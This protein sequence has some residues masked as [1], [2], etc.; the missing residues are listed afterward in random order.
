MSTDEK[1]PSDATVEK[2]YAQLLAT[3]G[4]SGKTSIRDRTSSEYVIRFLRAY[5]GPNFTKPHLANIYTL[6]F[7]KIKRT[8]A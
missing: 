6:M 2:S 3:L 4:K 1:S 8:S 5:A 7:R